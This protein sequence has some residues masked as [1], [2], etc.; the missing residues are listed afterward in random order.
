[1]KESETEKTIMKRI[2]EIFLSVPDEEIYGE[3]LQV[4]LKAMESRFGI[5]GYIDSDGAWVSPSLTRDIWSRCQMPDKDIVFP[6]KIWGGMWG[7]ALLEKRTIYSNDNFNV[8]EGHIPIIRAMDVP[9]IY[10]GELIGNIL[11]GNKETD[12]NKKDKKLLEII[13][14]YISP[15][16][17]ARLQRDE[18]EKAH[19]KVEEELRISI[20]EAEFYLDLMSHDINNTNQ[21]ALLSAEMLA[22]D[23]SLTER[24]R[25]LIDR[26]SSSIE[27]SSKIIKNVKNMQRIKQE[28]L[29]LSAIDLNTILVELADEYSSAPDKKV[30]IDYKPSN[31]KVLA[32][33]LLREV[34]SNLLNNSIKYSGESV[35]ITIKAETV[36]DGI[37]VSIEDN[38]KGISDEMK[39]AIFERFKRGKESISGSGLGLYLVRTLIRN[40]G[41][42]I[43]VENMVSGD[44][45][46]GSRFVINLPSAG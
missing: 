4:I 5:F 26:I 17:N 45:T 8:P 43:W 20:E 15:I 25:K 30:E 6:K 7:K 19:E 12:Y 10:K 31:L 40:Y 3:V 13:A 27:E 28:E 29:K 1:M 2:A 42:S 38:G 36:T 34:F 11:V 33:D 37:N 35:A 44:Y 32:N 21:V 18:K 39:E 16:L 23:N 14:R 41:G 46:Q 22:L 24:Q 9:I